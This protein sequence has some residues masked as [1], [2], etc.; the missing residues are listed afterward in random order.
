MS[1]PL[2]IGIAVAVVGIFALGGFFLW[3]MRT[4]PLP[5]PP[6]IQQEDGASVSNVVVEVERVVY[7]T[8]EDIGVNVT[9]SGSGELYAKYSD[10]IH[11]LVDWERQEG[12]LE[13]WERITDFQN[14]PERLLWDYCNS[15]SSGAT[16]E[17][18]VSPYRGPYGFT[19][20]SLPEDSS[21]RLVFYIWHNEK[22]EGEPEMI[23]SEEFKIEDHFPEVAHL[24]REKNAFVGFVE[25]I[26]FT[27]DAK[28]EKF[29]FCDPQTSYK[30]QS[31]YGYVVEDGKVLWE[32]SAY[33][34]SGGFS[35]VDVEKDGFHEI[36]W[37]SHGCGGTCTGCTTL[38]S[39]Y[40]PKHEETFSRYERIEFEETCTEIID[41]PT[42]Y[43]PNL[44]ESQFQIFR[45]YLDLQ[46]YVYDAR[47]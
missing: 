46:E 23:V 19:A 37:S 26:N 1:K 13:D 24:C 31:Y 32:Q 20:S 29:V 9:N 35:A 21:F 6:E 10:A 2:V 4:S 44:K 3:Q 11:F 39:L 27:E 36:Y 18:S 38:F 5:A 28:N 17:T 15:I 33:G 12:S 42:E 30:G 25:E 47:G 40:S 7:A 41:L 34:G 14:M 22:C 45:N 43:S 16:I 8:N